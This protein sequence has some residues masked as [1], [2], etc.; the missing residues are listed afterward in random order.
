LI[1]RA[2]PIVLSMSLAC[3]SKE[4]IAPGARM[5]LAQSTTGDFIRVPGE[6]GGTIEFGPNA[7]L[8]IGDED[9]PASDVYLTEWGLIDKTGKALASWDDSRFARVEQVD[10]AATVAIAACAA[11][12]VVAV[13][14]LLKS[15]SNVGNGGSKSS[16]SGSS[17]GGNG[18]KAAS[19]RSAPNPSPIVPDPHP[20]VTEVAFRTI[21]VVANN[22]SGP[23]VSVPVTGDEE[24][25]AAIPLFSRGARRRAIVRALARLEGG[26]CWPN[27]AGDCYLSGGRLGVRL[28]D[29]LE[30]SGGVRVESSAT[31]SRPL[32]VFGGMLHGELPAAHWFALAVGAS[33]A[34]DGS[35]AHVMPTLAI[36]LRP[37]R[38]FWLGLM[39][40]VPVYA[41]ETGG[42]TVTSGLELT[43]EL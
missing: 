26:V 30:L 32:P 14:M 6:S 5:A 4:T 28:F 42:W 29:M 22:S 11:I 27:A 38:G 40:I 43:G 34:F 7:T 17:G 9:V 25:D 13:A 18:P 8:H 39:P 19:T 23:S 21:E 31:L 10:G 35:R 33:V 12:V 15:G 2:L 16:G 37:V 1:R 24:P 20:A 41:A 3:T 36:R